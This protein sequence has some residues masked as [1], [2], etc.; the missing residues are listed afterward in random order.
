MDTPEDIRMQKVLEWKE[1]QRMAMSDYCEKCLEHNENCPFYDSEDE[2]W[3]YL[4]C[5]EVRG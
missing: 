1:A 4:D 2:Y 5:F 3:D